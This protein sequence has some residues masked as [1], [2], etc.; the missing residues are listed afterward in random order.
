MFLDHKR[1]S[2]PT[3]NAQKR[4]KYKKCEEE[5]DDTTTGK[6]CTIIVCA[7]LIVSLI[8]IFLTK[9][10]VIFF[11]LPISSLILAVITPLERREEKIKRPT[12]SSSFSCN[13][14]VSSKTLKGLNSCSNL[15]LS[16][17]YFALSF[18]YQRKSLFR[19]Y[20]LFAHNLSNIFLIISSQSCGQTVG[21]QHEFH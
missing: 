15:T 20:T 5:E 21:L 14:A 2:T 16:V 7:L 17:L 11:T 9:K 8:K 19:R 3:K 18:S 13:L 10:D 12:S 1:K 6:T 4:A